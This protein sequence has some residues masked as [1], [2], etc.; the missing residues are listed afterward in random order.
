T[1]FAKQPIAEILPKIGET[2]AL[3]KP[4]T[5]N[6]VS[7]PQVSKGVHN[8][9]VIAPRIFRISPNKISREAKKIPNTVSASSRT[10]PITVSQ[11]NAIIKKNMNSDLNGLSST[12]LDNTKTRRPQPRSNTKNDRVLSTSKSSR[13]KN[14]EAKV[15]EHHR[16]LLLSKKNKHISSACNNSKINSQDVISKDVCVVCKKCLNSVNHDVCLNNYVNGKKSRGRKHKE[17]ISKNETQQKNQPEIKKPKKVGFRKSLVTPKPRKPRFL[18]RWSPTGKMFDQDGKL[19]APS[20][21]ESHVDCSNGCSKHMTRNLKLLINF[22]W[23]FL[24]T[25]HFGN[26][27]VAAILGF[28]DLQWG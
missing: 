26:D 7:T 28:G 19:V 15:K 18:L 24:G 14:N 4:V 27:H 2:N 3:S 6:F 16:N 17:N 25:V 9:K 11:P 5:Y 10:K 22:V 12:G 23:K 21:S 13:S 8:D 1:K 20:N